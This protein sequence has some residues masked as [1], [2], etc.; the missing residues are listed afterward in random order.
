M[1]SRSLTLTLHLSSPRCSRIV[2]PLSIVRGH[3]QAGKLVPQSASFSALLA[4]SN[5]EL[6]SLCFFPIPQSTHTHTRFLRATAYRLARICHGNFVRLSNACFV[7]KRLNASSKFFHWLIRASFKFFVTTRRYVNLMASP[8][9]GAPN[10]REG[11]AIFDQYAAIVYLGNAAAATAAT[12]LLL[13]LLVVV[14]VQ[15]M[16]LL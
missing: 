5:E 12:S 8:P 11:V 15:L 13:L 4:T 14:V 6:L 3:S 10:T 9:E 7:S 2:C 1:I 16:L